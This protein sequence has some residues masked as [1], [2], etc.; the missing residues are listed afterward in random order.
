MSIKEKKSD[1]VFCSPV[2]LLALCQ[3]NEALEIVSAE[4]P[5]HRLLVPAAAAGNSHI[6][7]CLDSVM[8]AT[9]L[10][11]EKIKSNTKSTSFL[12]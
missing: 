2:S 8:I 7:A 1:N 4:Y 3:Y 5:E 10:W 11:S 6:L 9:E 12:L